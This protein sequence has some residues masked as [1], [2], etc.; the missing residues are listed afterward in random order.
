[1]LLPLFCQ[2]VQGPIGSG[3]DQIF[4][5]LVLVWLDAGNSAG[6]G[7]GCGDAIFSFEALVALDAGEGDGE[8]LCHLLLGLSL[9][10]GSQDPL[11]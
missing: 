5:V 9:C 8:A 3:G 1:M 11:A 7:L 6:P 2:G 4:E 10:Q